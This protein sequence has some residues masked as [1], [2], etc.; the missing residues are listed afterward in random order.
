MN[1]TFP[2]Y[3]IQRADRQESSDLVGRGFA[4]LKSGS[5]GDPRL[6]LSLSVD[7]LRTEKRHNCPQ[8]IMY[9][10]VIQNLNYEFVRSFLR[11]LNYPVDLFAIHFRFVLNC[12]VPECWFLELKSKMP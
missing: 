12:H 5:D 4:D 7:F 11:M 9:K 8:V 6:P 2:E 3:Q 10:F 1:F